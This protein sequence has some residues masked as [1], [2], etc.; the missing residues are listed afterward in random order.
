VRIVD[1]LAMHSKT[2]IPTLYWDIF[3]RVIDN[4][5]DVGVCWRLCCN[6]A[7]R[8]QTVR[9]WLDDTAALR[10]M[11]PL[12]APGV[13]IQAWNSR[14]T[15][16]DIT[17]GDVLVE[18]FGCD[19][20][21]EFIAS[22]ANRI[23]ARA[24]KCLWIN[25]EYLSAEPY[26]ACCHGLASPVMSGPGQGLI[27]HFFYPGFTPDTGGLL[28]EVDFLAR[29]ARFD[30]TRWLAQL[31]VDWRDQ[32][33]VSLFCYEPDALSDLLNSLAVDKQPTCLLVTDGRASAAVRAKVLDKNKLRPLWNSREVLSIYYLP[34]LT[35][36]DFDHLLWASD[37]NF[38]RGED[39]LVR[40][41][42]AGK[43][44]VWQIYPQDDGAHAVK[45]QAFQ[46]W[47]QAPESLRLAY[48]VWNGLKAEDLLGKGSSPIVWH[49]L[50]VWQSTVRQARQNLLSQADLT[51][52]LLQFVSKTP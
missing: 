24:Q 44:F 21:P 35:Q 28:R 12:G 2:P 3:C 8:G 48:A 25:L 19:I 9:L 4:F 15:Q 27:K 38:V 7:Q 36:T 17:P 23:S 37:L 50:G 32:R 41:L 51:T 14:H 34:P 43:P 39:S 5:G 11:A 16:H 52:Q 26:V 20:D 42:L 47:L 33:L 46:D 40:A 13:T 49:E 30:R 45:L 22:Y 10:W 29:Q 18:A 31:G 1:N 6:L